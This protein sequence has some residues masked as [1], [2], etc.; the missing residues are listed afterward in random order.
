MADGPAGTLE[1]PPGDLALRQRVDPHRRVVAITGTASF[2]GRQLL[3]LLEDDPRYQRVLAVDVEPPSEPKLRKTAFHKIDLTQPGADAELARLFKAKGVD[4]LAHLAFLSRPTHNSAWAHELEAIGTMHVL[5]AAAA[6][7]L[8]KVLLWSLTALY[9]AHADNPMYLTE[10]SPRRS[11]PE[12]RFFGDKLEAERLT[13]RFAAENPAATVTV[14]RTAPILGQ[15]ID[16]FVSRFFASPVVPTVLGYDP[17]IQL[18]GEDDA[19][20]AFKICLDADFPGSFNI[21]G[22]GVLPLSTVL[23]MAGRLTLPLPY[24]LAL[25]GT[26]LLWLAQLVEAPPRFIDFLRYSCLA[27]TN[28]SRREMSF[29]PRQDIRQVIRAFTQRAPETTSSE[30]ARA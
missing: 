23:A 28:K 15:H 7:P 10:E 6:C 19:V 30:E 24:R 12:S 17:L 2:L 11:I 21:A 5:N 18:L 4:S 27:D 1:A 25:R 14:L 13:E 29:S 8:R 3:G 20:G 22:D 16:N 26:R 9:G